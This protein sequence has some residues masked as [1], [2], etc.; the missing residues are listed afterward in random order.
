VKGRTKTSLRCPISFSNNDKHIMNVKK[1]LIAKI[2]P[3]GFILLIYGAE[4][5]N[6][7]QFN[8]KIRFRN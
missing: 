1:L 6:W 2:R 5:P 3:E 7:S 8:L 4:S